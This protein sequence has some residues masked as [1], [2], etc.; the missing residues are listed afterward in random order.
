MNKSKCSK[1]YKYIK[2]GD[3]YEFAIAVKVGI[4]THALVFVTPPMTAAAFLA[5]IDDFKLKRTAYK[6][7]GKDQKG[8]YLIARDLLYTT[9]SDF[10]LYVD[11]IANGDEN[12]IILAGFVPTKTST[13]EKPLPGKPVASLNQN[14]V[15]S[16][17]G[18]CP[19]VSDGQ[20]YGGILTNRPFVGISVTE[21]GE[22]EITPDPEGAPDRFAKFTFSMARKKTFDGL[23]SGQRYYLYMWSVNTKG[24]GAISDVV[25]QVCY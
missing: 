21:E 14:G 23:I 16:L 5:I 6:N 3:L 18:E 4:Y 12:I 15:G 11:P 1:S 17:I 20:T 22:L 25:N 13:S 9:L 2:I 7:G 8:D 19:I 24:A 10:G